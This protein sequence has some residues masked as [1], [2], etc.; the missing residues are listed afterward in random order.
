MSL[1]YTGQ[2]LET[3]ICFNDLFDVDDTFFNSDMAQPLLPWLV[4]NFFSSVIKM[5]FNFTRDGLP[6]VSG[7]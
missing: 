6:S 4:W 3:M 2:E 7:L 5:N 1:V